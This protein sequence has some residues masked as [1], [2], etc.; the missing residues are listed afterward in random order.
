[1][2]GSRARSA[3]SVLNVHTRAEY[4]YFL[5]Y[6]TC[7]MLVLAHALS[8]ARPCWHSK[9][10]SQQRGL[11]C[12]A[13]DALH[14]SN[15]FSLGCTHHAWGLSAALPHADSFAPW[16]FRWA[17]HKAL[18]SPDGPWQWSGSRRFCRPFEEREVCSQYHKSCQTSSVRTTTCI[19]P[20]SLLWRQCTYL[21][22]W[23]RLL[24]HSSTEALYSISGWRAGATDKRQS[25]RFSK[26][27]SPE[28]FTFTHPA[29]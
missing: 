1:M 22:K 6:S 3:E 29:A 5:Q 18:L 9:Q 20:S 21:P 7:A 24:Q 16:L 12:L 27:T 28:G 11:L 26:A 4:L 10:W 19:I 25:A 15:P 8:C 23:L 13:L 14:P 2:E 17:L